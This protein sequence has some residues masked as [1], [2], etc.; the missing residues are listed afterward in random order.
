VED[1]PLRVQFAPSGIGLGHVGRCVPIARRLEKDGAKI[2]FSTYLEGVQYAR[3]EG[4]STVEVPPVKIAVKPD[5]T[6]DFRQSMVDP[7]PFFTSFTVLEQVNAEIEVMKAFKPNVVVSD[8]RGSPLIAAKLLQIPRVCILNQF[9]I[10]IPRT[11]QFLRLAKL[12]DAGSLAVVGKIWTSVT[13]VLIPDFPPP[14]T[15]STGNLRIPDFYR[16][17]VKFIGPILPVYPKELPS[18]MELRE[19]LKL[20]HDKPLIFAPIS[21]PIKQR[22]FFTGILRRIFKEF[23]EEYQIVMSLG[24]PNA[25]THP[26]RNKNVTVYKWLPNRFDY[27]KAC[28]LVIARAGHGTLMQSICYGKPLI[29]VPTPS[30]TEQLNNARRAVELGI[31]EMVEQDNLNKQALLAAVQK[32]LKLNKLKARIMEI[33]E[34]VIKLNGLETAAQIIESAGVTDK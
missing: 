5:G 11:R 13:R 14:Y 25:S 20:S 21:G 16:K 2:L 1:N 24:Y 18:E 10:I 32:M 34:D 3:Q 8:S 27:L 23:P 15:I 33:Q 31:A 22:A 19:K 29:L 26:I 7:G 4:F 9:Q 17:K 6:V 28:D 30:Q 12:A